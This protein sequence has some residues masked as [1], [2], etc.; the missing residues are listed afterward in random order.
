V[1]FVL[2]IY[3]GTTPLP[4]NPDDWA[5]LSAQEQKAIYKDYVDR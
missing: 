5:T 4:T 3:Q 2:L 1:Q